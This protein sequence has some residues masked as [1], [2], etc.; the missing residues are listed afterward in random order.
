M[1]IA[2]LTL[3]LLRIPFRV[4]FKHASAER[5]ITQSALVIAQSESGLTGYGEGCPRDYVTGE[6]DASVAMFFELH[7]DDILARVTDLKTLQAWCRAHEGDIDQNPAAWCAIELALL[8]LFARGNRLPVEAFLGLPLLAGPFFYSAV[9]G[10]T[11]AKQFAETLNRYRKIGMRDFKI[12]LS[13]DAGR[14]RANLAVLRAA[15]IGPAQVRADA[16]NLWADAHVAQRYLESLDYPFVAIEEPLRP[17]QFA[18]LAA[19]A[20]SL[21]IRIVLDESIT[22]E[23]QLAQLPG[24]PERWIVNLRVSKMGGLLRSLQVVNRCRQA[25]LALVVGAQ[26]G[27]TSLLTRAALVVAQAARDILIAQE[28]A[29]GTLLLESDAVEPALMFGAKGELDILSSRLAQ[30]PG[31]GLTPILGLAERYFHRG[32]K[33]GARGD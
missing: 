6:T 28:G 13:G 20:E 11:D 32:T 29:Y 23:E 5:N 1:H 17:G 21:A 24:A 19:L 18:D 10:A 8:D 2:S 14:D 26:V 3:Q 16:N 33:E 22:R 9:L 15:D 31:L 12:K 7:R 27:E 4:A 25:G 30:S